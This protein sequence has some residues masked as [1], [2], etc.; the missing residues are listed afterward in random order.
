MQIKSGQSYAGAAGEEW[1]RMVIGVD[2]GEVIYLSHRSSDHPERPWMI[3]W[4]PGRENDLPSIEKAPMHQFA[5]WATRCI[6]E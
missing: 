1:N 4:Q 3:K 6:S 5:S 2:N